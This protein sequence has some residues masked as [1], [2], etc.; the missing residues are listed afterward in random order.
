MRLEWTVIWNFVF[1]FKTWCVA[2]KLRMFE[3]IEENKLRHYGLLYKYI[4][5]V[6][7]SQTVTLDI[8]EAESRG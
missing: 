7:K 5:W 2:H 3:E 4:L 8:Y 1:W 6:T